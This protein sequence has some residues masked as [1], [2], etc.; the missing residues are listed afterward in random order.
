MPPELETAASGH[1]EITISGDTRAD[2]G[3]RL[4]NVDDRLIGRRCC[5]LE[6]LK[7]VCGCSEREGCNHALD[8]TVHI[9]ASS[10]GLI[11]DIIVIWKSACFK[12][13]KQNCQFCSTTDLRR[14]LPLQR[15]ILL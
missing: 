12:R 7:P 5:G 8:G 6:T 11:Q 14:Y 1:T 2:W 13:M 4:V 3:L 10:I 9:P 15:C